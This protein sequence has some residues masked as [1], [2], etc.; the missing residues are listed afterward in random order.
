MGDRRSP[1]HRAGSCQVSLFL[2]PFVPVSRPACCTQLQR[3]SEQFSHLPAETAR[4]GPLPRRN[5]CGSPLCNICA[6]CS[7]S[8]GTV[9]PLFVRGCAG[10]AL[11]EGSSPRP[12]GWAPSL[13]V[14][15][16][17]CLETPW[18]LLVKN[19]TL[20]S[21]RRSG[22]D[23]SAPQCFGSS[24]GKWLTLRIPGGFPNP[25]EVKAGTWKPRLMPF[26]TTPLTSN[27]GLWA[28]QQL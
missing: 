7:R 23:G 28:T 3:F 11:E 17:N 14:P 5:R 12:T 15:R 20:R 4:R 25:G 8:F 24:G 1:R 13:R 27:S 18:F 10:D 19:N 9:L 6:S 16:T 2:L 21:L 22:I 26:L